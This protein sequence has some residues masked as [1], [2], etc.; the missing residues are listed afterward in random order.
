MFFAGV[1]VLAG[2]CAVAHVLFG[3][4]VIDEAP[5]LLARWSG[6]VGGWWAA[7]TF[8]LVQVGLGAFLTQRWAALSSIRRH[9][10]IGVVA[11]FSIGSFISYVLLM[12][13]A[14][15]K[16][17]SPVGGWAYAMGGLV[18]GG[19]GLRELLASWPAT[20]ARLRRRHLPSRWALLAAGLLLMIWLVPLLTQSLLPNSDW[21]AAAYHLPLADRLFAGGFWSL[22]PAYWWFASPGLAHLFY[23]L[24][25]FAGLPQA[26]I[27]LNL[28]VSAL[29][30]MGVF[31]ATLP[32]GGRKTAMLAAAICASQSLLWEVG[33]TARVDAFLTLYFLVAM[34]ALAAWVRDRSNRGCLLLFGISLGLLLGLK[35]ISCVFAAFAGMGM[36]AALVLA[37]P[38]GRWHEVR[39]VGYGTIVIALLLMVVPSAFWYAR[40]WVEVGDPLYMLLRGQVYLDQSGRSIPSDPLLAPFLKRRMPPDA[41]IRREMGNSQFASPLT[42][43]QQHDQRKRT[44]GAAPRTLLPF[45]DVALMSWQYERKALHTVNVLL[46]PA[47]LL[48]VVWWRRRQRYRGVMICYLV[49]LAAFLLIGRTTFIV[50]YVMALLP[51]AAIGSALV[52][53]RW[54]MALLAGLAVLALSAWRAE[55]IAQ[56]APWAYH[57]SSYIGIRWTSL[58]YAFRIGA[59]VLSILALLIWL[60]ARRRV[61][62]E[63]G[64]ARRL[65]LYGWAIAAVVALEVGGL[66][67]YV[68]LRDDLRPIPYLTAKDSMTSWLGHVGYNGVTPMGAYLQFL[69]KAVKHRTIPRDA[70]VMM[71]GECKGYMMPLP[72]LPDGSREGWRWTQ[73]LIRADGDLDRVAENLWRQHVRYLLINIEYFRWVAEAEEPNRRQLQSTLYTLQKFASRYTRPQPLY[74]DKSMLM[75]ELKPPERAL[76][77]GPCPFRVDPVPATSADGRR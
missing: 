75:L 47:F 39:R 54:R 17:L 7:I 28:M 40:N 77:Q 72:W 33:L 57:F 65:A 60:P 73:E 46:L 18:V 21:D 6:C 70:A 76:P 10:S 26:I 56:R 62:L 64:P 43:F 42:Y 50:R 5:L 44:A 66:Q 20:P 69:S 36:L 31:G 51:L 32:I 27:P 1:W 35:H 37:I 41:V 61:K 67:E 63:L 49:T 68:K 12:A 15:A 48:P 13:L 74:D 45:W 8:G 52:L 9:S 24:F 29:V 53:S 58:P 2:L 19:V 11:L 14:M 22:D 71:V 38:L 23:G 3:R 25:Q 4:E 34:Y 59:A 16:L 30:A 55:E